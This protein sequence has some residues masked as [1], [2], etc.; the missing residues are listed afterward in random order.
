MSAD[1]IPLELSVEVPPG[2]DILEH[3]S[4]VETRT[5]ALGWP[6]PHSRG[7]CFA[8]DVPVVDLAYDVPFNFDR[9]A[10]AIAEIRRAFTP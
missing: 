4:R 3:R 9:L 5:R 2:A 8:H 6:K 10:Q 1:T 7:T